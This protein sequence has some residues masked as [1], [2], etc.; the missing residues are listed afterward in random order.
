MPSR[1]GRDAH[2]RVAFD[3]AAFAEDLGHSA[4]NASAAAQNERDALA[5]DGLLSNR[6]KACEDEGRDGT[7]LPGCAKVYIPEPDGPWGMVF[8]L[9]VD[10][11]GRPYM[12]CL[13]FGLRHPTG[14]GVLS[15]YEVADRR[16]HT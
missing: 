5:K 12:A 13:A 7:R 3:D 11:D 10:Q 4:P 2:F 9:R 15:V 6:L 16:L 8:E 14:P 1:S